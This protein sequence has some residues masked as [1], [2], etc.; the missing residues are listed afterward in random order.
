MSADGISIVTGQELREALT[1]N[2]SDL[3]ILIAAQRKEIEINID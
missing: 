2:R 3:L 1:D